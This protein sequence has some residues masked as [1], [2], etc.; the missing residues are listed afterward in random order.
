[1]KLEIGRIFIKDIQLG[2][3]TS[4]KNG[5]LTVDKEGLIA[6]LKEDERIKDVALDVA[7]PGEKVRIIPVKDVIE[8]RVKIEGGNNGFPGVTSKQA[9]CGEGKTNV[10]YGA[11]VVTVG[12]VVGFQEGVIDM[13][14][15]GAKW[16]PFSKTYNLTVDIS[17][18]DG[19]APHAHEETVRLAGLRAAEFVGL[20]G[21]DVTPDEV[22]TYE[23]G[24]IFEETAKYPNLPKVLYAEMMITQGLLH[25]TYIYGVNA[26]TILPSIL[27]PF[28]ELDNAVISG[29]CVAACD[30]ITT[31]QHQNNSVIEDL[32]AQHGK[33]INFLGCIM[34]PEHT[35]LAGKL[36][37][38]NYV[39]KLAKMFGADA[40]VVSEEG[41][42]NPDS[43]LL[44]ICKK[45]EK[46]GIV[47][48]LITDEC[49]GRDGM[50]QPLAD[51][52]QEAVAVVSGGNV[53]HVVTLP[54]ADKVI[55][56]AAAI[57]V[58]AGG[59]DGALLE[60]GTLM[61]ELNAVIGSTSEIGYHNVTCRLY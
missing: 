15:E 12:D 45:C 60:D 2:Q 8:P 48:Q 24:S 46:A 36:R 27:H 28:E 5:V 21:K 61:C 16:T 10:L 18:V 1:M 58:L 23:M 20:A 30:K 33:E 34:V 40:V 4:V 56:N 47:T 37:V 19:L 39:L 55:G 59:W 50:S 54:P 3:E 9:Q 25:D 44:M 49:A 38:S 41:Y 43:D 14:G 7:K 32:Y 11:A 31:Y 57:A 13:W 42:G 26:Q 22:L 29:N 53:S 6:K 51:T 35:T 52:A 17:V